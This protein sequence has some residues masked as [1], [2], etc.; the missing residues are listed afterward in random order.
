MEFFVGFL[1]EDNLPVQFSELFNT[2]KDAEAYKNELNNN[3]YMDL[4]DFKIF[5]K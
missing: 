2:K 5:M 1:G 4:L 3:P